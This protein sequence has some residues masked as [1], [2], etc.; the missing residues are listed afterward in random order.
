MKKTVWYNKL[1]FYNNPL[2]IKPAAFHDELFGY[3]TILKNINEK[4]MSNEV[5]LIIGKYGYG[6]T[7]ILK[8][9]IN[10]FMGKK[11]VVYYNCNQTEESI[12]FDR[13]LIGAGGFFSKLFKI[14]KKNMILLLDEVQDASE[15]DLKLIPDYYGSNFFRSVVFVTTKKNLKFP[16]KLETLIGKNVFKITSI[17]RAEGVK[18]I[19]KRIGDLKLLSDGMILEI[20]KKNSKPR[21]LLKNCEDVCKYAVENDAEK[22]TKRHVKKVLG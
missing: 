18:L 20:F 16:K 7:T 4:V 1:G 14:R 2:S 15:K 5:L 3:D 13:L 10:K 11:E 9:I 19:R 12:D 6:K 8:K 22:V 17:G 21:A